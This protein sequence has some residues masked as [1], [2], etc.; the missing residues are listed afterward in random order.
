MDLINKK[1]VHGTFGE[2]NIVN[3]SGK[4]LKVDF[5]KVGP[6]KFVYPDVFQKYMKLVDQ[7]VANVVDDKIEEVKKQREEE[8]SQLQRE[9][10]IEEERRDILRRERAIK[11]KKIHPA[12]QSVFWCQPDEIDQIFTDW[13]VFV[14]EIKSGERKGEPRRLARMDRNSVCLLTRRTNDEPEKNRQIIGA[15]MVDVNPD[16]SSFEDGYIPARPEYR[17]RLSEEESEEMLFWNYY[18]NKREPSRIVWK[19]GRQRYFDNIWMAQILRDIIS[20]RE[21][22][23]EKEDIKLFYEYFCQINSIDMETLSEANGALLQEE[24]QNQ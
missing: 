1:V 2:G 13:E 22:S 5:A 21:D 8:E 11:N 7:E 19:S 24:N 10:E 15:F 23:E 20:L 17:I 16:G 14:G 9:R 4:Y 3:H 12:S 6:K 18:S